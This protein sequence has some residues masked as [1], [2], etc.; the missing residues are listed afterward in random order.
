MLGIGH[1]GWKVR[2]GRVTV[3]DAAE[4]VEFASGDGGGRA[5]LTDPL[6]ARAIILATAAAP[7]SPRCTAYEPPGG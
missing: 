3:E 1:R 2:G 7:L 4:R 5:V 6:G